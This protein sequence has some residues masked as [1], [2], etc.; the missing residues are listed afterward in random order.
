MDA[1]A[2]PGGGEPGPA[3]AATGE[4]PRP[5][6]RWGPITALAV[7][8]KA[9]RLLID[10]AID[11]RR[12]LVQ[13]IGGL[14][15]EARSSHRRTVVQA[16]GRLGADQAATFRRLRG[17]LEQMDVPPGGRPCH[18]AVG[19]WLD[20]VVAACDAMVQ[21]GDSGDLKHLRETQEHLAA[22]RTDARRFNA[23][24]ERLLADLKQRVQR[25]STAPARRSRVARLR[26]LLGRRRQPPAAQ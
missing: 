19:R 8:L 16:T 7:Y 2:E 24:Y 21:V 5:V 17:R 9:L 15:D 4:K 11:S 12:S 20:Q 6:R 10:D 22:S 14:L 26:G 1:E 18:D 13:H 3:P 23:E 25:A